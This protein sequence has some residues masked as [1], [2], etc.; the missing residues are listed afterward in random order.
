MRTDVRTIERCL[1]VF[2][3]L[4]PLLRTSVD[5][6][7]TNCVRLI[8]WRDVLAESFATLLTFKPWHDA[9]SARFVFGVM[10]MRI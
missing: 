4:V 5:V 7:M 2:F 9:T 3:V 6:Q 8:F 1:F 10:L